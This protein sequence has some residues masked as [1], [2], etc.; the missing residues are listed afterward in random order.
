[1]QRIVHPRVLGIRILL[2]VGTNEI[3]NLREIPA[4]IV[5]SG[6]LVGALFFEDTLGTLVSKLAQDP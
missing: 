5:F 3:N 2:M 1:M 4:F 6:A